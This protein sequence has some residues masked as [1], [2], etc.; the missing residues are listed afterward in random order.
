MARTHRLI[1]RASGVY[2]A[3]AKITI[4]PPGL[5]PLDFGYRPPIPA[6]YTLFDG[7]AANVSPGSTQRYYKDAPSV[8]LPT[9]SGYSGSAGGNDSSFIYLVDCNFGGAFFIRDV[10]DIYIY[11]G[12]VGPVADTDTINIARSA[13]TGKALCYEPFNLL[14]Q[15]IYAHDVTRTGSNHVDGMQQQGGSNINFRYCM[16][17]RA[18]TQGLFAK[19]GS[20][21]TPRNAVWERNYCNAQL[22][23]GHINISENGSIVCQNIAVRDNYTSSGGANVDA[24]CIAAGCSVSNTQSTS[25]WPYPA[26]GPTAY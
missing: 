2:V 26:P 5:G 7:V 20:F 18:G 14:F 11:G 16:L 19:G 1:R 15:G 3:K 21:G 13:N 17:L 10:H 22:G 8:N 24:S 12:Q 6:G 9:R 4:S 23:T 25:A